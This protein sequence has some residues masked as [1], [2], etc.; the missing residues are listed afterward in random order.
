MME[1]LNTI[2]SWLGWIVVIMM[3]SS[4]IWGAVAVYQNSKDEK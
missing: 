2:A 4:L 3:V 1:Q